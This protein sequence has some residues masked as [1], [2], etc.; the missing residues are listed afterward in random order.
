VSASTVSMK[1]C[2]EA[3]YWELFL[4][5]MHCPVAKLGTFPR[6]EHIVVRLPRSFWGVGAW[7]GAYKSPSVG[8]LPFGKTYV[9]FTKSTPKPLEPQATIKRSSELSCLCCALTSVNISKHKKIVIKIFTVF[10]PFSSGRRVN[11]PC[12]L[13][14]IKSFIKFP[15]QPKP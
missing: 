2:F 11:Y 6:R 14:R 7:K 5:Y 10:V 4:D 1:A 12:V 8:F 13:R 9:L 15:K 3:F